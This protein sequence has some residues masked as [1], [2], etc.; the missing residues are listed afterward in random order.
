MPMKKLLLPLLLTSHLSALVF[1]APVTIGDKPGF[2][3]KIATSLE[4]KKGNTDKENYKAVLRVAYDN[5]T[6]HVTWM[7]L[8]GEYG[9]VNN[10]Q[11]TGKAFGHLR[12]IHATPLEHFNFELFAQLQEDEFKLIKNRSLAGAGVRYELFSLLDNDKF[13]FGL[14]GFYEHVTYTSSDPNESNA[15]MNSYLAYSL[16]FGDK[17]RFSYTLYFQPKFSDF[18]D[19]AKSHAMELRLVVYEKLFLQLNLNYDVDS[20]PAIGVK[21]YDFMQ[22]TSLVLEF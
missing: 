7:E 14:G 6:S 15:R 1:I 4:T 20:E 18:S 19:Y 12:H 9:E 2:N 13:Y 21:E 5:N 11:D 17:S 10:E 22:T 3:T 16:N 8:S